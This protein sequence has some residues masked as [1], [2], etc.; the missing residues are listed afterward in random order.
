[1]G[2]QK[3]DKDFV[4]TDDESLRKISV[5]DFVSGRIFTREVVVKQLPY[6]GFLIVLAFIYISNHFQMEKLLKKAATLN[7]EIQEL[8]I[9]SITTSSDLMYFSKQSVILDKVRAAGVDL[10]ELTDPPRRIEI[11]KK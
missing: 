3:K 9:E 4:G 7:K 10:E 5:R 6:F 8:R 11:S 1:M 2:K